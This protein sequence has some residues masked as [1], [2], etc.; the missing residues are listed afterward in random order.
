MNAIEHG[1]ADAGRPIA[2]DFSTN[3]N[4]LGPPPGVRIAVE[5]AERGR[6]PDPQYCDLREQLAHAHD[7]APADVLPSAG[8]SE[9]IRRLTLAAR[10]HG[11]QRVWL[12]QPGYG[13]YAA[14]ASALGLETCPYASG[15]ALLDGLRRE[16][17]QAMVWLCEPCNPTGQSLPA[18]FWH[19]LG[20]LAQAR[21]VMLAIDRAYEPL[22]LQD[23]D[24]VPS[25]L[26]RRAWQCHSPN[27]A[28]GMTG[29]RA[30]YVIAPPHQTLRQAV[31]SL[32]PS[33]VLSAE[34]VALLAAWQ[35]PQTRRWMAEARD[36]LVAWAN[37][38]RGLLHGLGW[39]QAESV[40]P[41]WLARPDAS[42]LPQSLTALRELGIKLRDARSFGLPGWVRISTQPPQSQQALASAWAACR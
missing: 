20:E 38:Q 33:W 11:V 1:G 14:A 24:P 22:R 9:A 28:L 3:A 16:E 32:A 6:Y 31:E 26:A 12:P 42:T 10:L 39:Q 35:A 30:G 34:G 5:Q 15:D 23:T 25:S 8:T 18:M 19:A 17:A 2:H 41:F 13:D 27:K 4:P 36:T 37:A 40:V 29:V 7:A 21:G